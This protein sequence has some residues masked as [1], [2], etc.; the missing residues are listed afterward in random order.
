MTVSREYLV[1][2]KPD[3]ISIRI[4]SDLLTKIDMMKDKEGI[5]RTA[6]IIRALRYWVAIEGNVTID[7]EFLNRLDKLE[8]YMGTIANKIN[9]ETDLRDQVSEQEKVIGALV[10]MIPK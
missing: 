6:L 9:S 7:N 5:D 8:K 3:M 10:K 1:M 2:K 4:P